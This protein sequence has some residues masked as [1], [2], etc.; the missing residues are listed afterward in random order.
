MVQKTFF[1]SNFSRPPLPAPS[2]KDLLTMGI[3][4]DSDQFALGGPSRLSRLASS[5]LDTRPSNFDR[6][7]L[8]APAHYA[9]YP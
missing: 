7:T 6:E 4:S 8:R 9:V 3:C 5:P 2:S 1:R